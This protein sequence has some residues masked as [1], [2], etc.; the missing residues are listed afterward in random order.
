VR[1]ELLTRAIDGEWWC[2]FTHDPGFLPLQL[3]RTDKGAVAVR[4]SSS[5]V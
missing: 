1:Q 2:Y 3:Q 4:A 5:G